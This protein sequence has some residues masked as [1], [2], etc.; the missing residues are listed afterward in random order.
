VTSFL[1]AIGGGPRAPR[2]GSGGRLRTA[3]PCQGLFVRVIHKYR[4]RGWRLA[5]H[6]LLDAHDPVETSELENTTVSTGPNGLSS[7]RENEFSGDSARS[8]VRSLPRDPLVVTASL[9]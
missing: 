4:A 7:T 1:P 2:S 8:K 3:I 6:P 5:G 9:P